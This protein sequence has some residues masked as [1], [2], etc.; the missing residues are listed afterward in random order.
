MSFEAEEVLKEFSTGLATITKLCISVKMS[1]VLSLGS[2]ESVGNW[3]ATQVITKRSPFMLG[4]S[5]FR[6][7]LSS[8]FTSCSRA[9]TNY[10][11]S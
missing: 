1:E 3:V 10:S 6:S 9:R 4:F 2:E 5:Y 11:M 8:K 7:W